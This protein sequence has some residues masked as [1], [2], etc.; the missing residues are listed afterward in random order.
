M[1]ECVETVQAPTVPP[2]QFTGC[3]PVVLRACAAQEHL[4]DSIHG[5]GAGVGLLGEPTSEDRDA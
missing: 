1:P 3:K 4:T 5:T 2:V